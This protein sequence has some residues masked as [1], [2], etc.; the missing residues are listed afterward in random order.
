MA[1]YAA[2]S[3]ALT[4]RAP[5]FLHD[6]KEATPSVSSSGCCCCVLHTP[7]SLHARMQ[8]THAAPACPCLQRLAHDKQLAADL[9][10]AS[11]AAVGLEEQ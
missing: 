10:A 7:R 6:C 1:V 4:A 2:T 9:W 11:A 3:P 8:L 5:L